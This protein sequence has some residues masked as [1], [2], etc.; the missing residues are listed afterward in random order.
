MHETLF[1]DALTEKMLAHLMKGSRGDV[2]IRNL[3]KYFI[4]QNYDDVGDFYKEQIE[5]LHMSNIDKL[6]NR[7]SDFLMNT[8]DDWILCALFQ[9]GQKIAIR[10][11]GSDIV[12]KG[13]YQCDEWLNMQVLVSY[14]CQEDIQALDVMQIL[15]EANATMYIRYFDVSEK[16]FCIDIDPGV[17]ELLMK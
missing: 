17:A 14:E 8:S 4:G 6:K 5:C 15:T 10:G 2:F 3:A 13:E 9:G 12:L 11:Y 1:I 7:I 16:T